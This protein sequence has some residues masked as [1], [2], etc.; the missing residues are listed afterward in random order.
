[1]GTLSTRFFGLGLGLG[2]A[3]L[4]TIPTGAE[5][6]AIRGDLRVGLTLLSID[7][8]ERGGE[9]YAEPGAVPIARSDDVASS[10]PEIL[11]PLRLCASSTT[12]PV[13]EMRVKR[14]LRARVV[15]WCQE[16]RTPPQ[17][18]RNIGWS[19]MSDELCFSEVM[20]AQVLF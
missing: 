20:E 6:A 16:T 7:F 8:T 13:G 12:L 1:M 14:V 5:R 4:P 3:E 19:V 18:S 2:L 17:G 10:S 11:T 9:E 15:D